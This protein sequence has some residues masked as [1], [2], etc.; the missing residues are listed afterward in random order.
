MQLIT[1]HFKNYPSQQKVAE[2]LL[3]QGIAVRDGDAY[4]GDIKQSDTAV[5]KAAGVDRRIVRATIEKISN[6][7]E[8][9]ALF[10]KLRPM[11]LL[12]EAARELGCSCIE[13][14]PTDAT[15]PGILAGI[16]DILYR[17]GI[18]VRQAVVSDPVDENA[19]HLLIVADGEIPGDV[20]SAVRNSRG[21]AEVIIK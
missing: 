1:D 11:L 21:V 18:S 20:L 9:L 6:T 2:V 12:S 7:P 16:M 8:L 14:V 17:A 13:V 5:A 4:C 15:M 19:S 3:R 10:S